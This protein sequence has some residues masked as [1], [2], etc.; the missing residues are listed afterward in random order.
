MPER[1]T[2]LASLGALLRGIIA[3]L[4]AAD[5]REPLVDWHEDLHDR[6]ALPSALSHDLRRVLGDLDEHELGLPA[7]LRI[8][9]AA[10]RAPGIT[11]Q[12][13]DA[14][15]E[16]RPAL[17]FWPLV[18]DVASQEHATSRLVDASTQRWEL[19]LSDKG[20]EAIAIAGKWAK[21]RPIGDGV[22]AIGV[23]RRIYQPSP[24]FH[25]GLPTQDP[26]V[27]EW[28]HGGRSQRIELWAWKP[29][30]GA[31]EGLP[32]DDEDALARRNER[33]Q[34]TTL[35]HPEVSANGYHREIRPFTI[36]LRLT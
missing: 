11:C 14:T 33:I 13:G 24:G 2:M 28:A 22:R 9:L 18:G 31:Y 35:D 7:Q 10:W 23:R 3:R 26:L 25:P 19:S 27:I 16:L 1:P 12:L 4:A 6:F 21:L 8:E 29:S 15:L 5:Y 30:G 34:I 36:D 17:E 20:P 32:T